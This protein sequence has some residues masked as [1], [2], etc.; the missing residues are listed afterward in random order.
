MQIPCSKNKHADALSKLASS[1]FSHLTRKVL[2]E[3]VP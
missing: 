3:V 1:S 2:E